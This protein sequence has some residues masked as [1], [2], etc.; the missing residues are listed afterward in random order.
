MKIKM[1]TLQ[2]GPT[3]VREVGSVH[4]VDDKE[5]KALIAGGYAIPVE[6]VVEKAVAKRGEKA[7]EPTE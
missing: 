6:K 5:A 3:G 1:L 7:T 4:D 2:A